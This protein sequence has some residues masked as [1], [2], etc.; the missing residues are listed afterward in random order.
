MGR[1]TRGG[2]WPVPQL[3][4]L[5][6]GYNLSRLQRF[7]FR[8][9]VPTAAEGRS[10]S[11]YNPDTYGDPV[12]RRRPGSTEASGSA[13]LFWS[14]AFDAAIRIECPMLRIGHFP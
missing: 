6:P 11:A 7:Y 2:D 5:A 4:S 1:V 12:L 9:A 10:D 13:P 14:S 8:A 3:A